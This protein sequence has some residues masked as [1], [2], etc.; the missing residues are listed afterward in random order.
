MQQL[1]L[2]QKIKKGLVP[3]PNWFYEPWVPKK[4]GD[5]IEGRLVAWED[6]LDKYKKRTLT[7]N[8]LCEDKVRRCVYVGNY[9]ELER[10]LEPVKEKGPT[11]KITYLSGRKTKTQDTTRWEVVVTPAA[12]DG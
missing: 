1:T 8:L 6:V 10:L 4:P 3:R 9:E 7:A 12:N 11:L 2:A 5:S